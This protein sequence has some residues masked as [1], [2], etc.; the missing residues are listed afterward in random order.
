MSSSVLKVMKFEIVRQVKKPMFW[1]AILAMP[2][3]ICGG[4]LI[5]ALANSGA[6]G[7]K[8]VGD[9]TKIAITDEAGILPVDNPF[10]M[11]DSKDAG[12]E[13]VK[14]KKV[15]LYYYVPADFA[16]TKKVESYRIS[17]G[18]GIFDQQAETLK[19][20]LAEYVRQEVTDLEALALTGEYVIND[21][22]FTS[23]GEDSNALGKAIIPAVFL[24]AFFIF[25]CV[26]GNRMLMTVVEEKENR[27]SEMLLTAVSAR[28]LIIGKILALLTLGMIQILALLIPLAVL[29]A[30]NAENE[31][32]A[33]VMGI[34]VVDPMSLISCILLFIFSILLF[35]GLCTYIGAITPT[36]KDASQFIG[37]IIIGVMMPLYFTQTFLSGEANG[38][39][40]FLTYFPLSAP[41]SLMMRVAVGS[42]TVPGLIAGIVEMIV[43]S[44]IVIRMTITTFQKN[45]IN[46]S[47]AVPKF[48]KR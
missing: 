28:H 14:E 4:F 1:V 8:T 45:A 3:L 29:V 18:L 7:A 27:V 20:I 15:D 48:L 23:S 22:K 6:E 17:D 2:V 12:I 38:L 10:K 9:D 11:Y 36:A 31:M 43:L 13:A 46:F 26:F 5:S 39:V 40:E 44:V 24:V 33:A 35:A 32:V 19:G 30:M 25:V 16:E 21:N 34:I 37:P 41:I 47:V 42:I